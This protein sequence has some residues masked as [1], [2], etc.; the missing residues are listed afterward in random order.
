MGFVGSILTG[1]GGPG[2]R[3]WGS[4][5]VFWRSVAALETTRGEQKIR[6]RQKVDSVSASHPILAQKKRQ[7]GAQGRHQGAKREP[8]DVQKEAKR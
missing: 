3:F 8:G 2:V 4:W 1:L 6:K 5:A 7:K